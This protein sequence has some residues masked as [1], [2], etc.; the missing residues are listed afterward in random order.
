VAGQ[1][2]GQ[3]LKHVCGD[4]SFP[5]QQTLRQMQVGVLPLR[6]LIMVMP[7]PLLFS[8]D[9]PVIE[10]ARHVPLRPVRRSEDDVATAI[11][12]IVADG[13]T[14]LDASD[15]GLHTRSKKEFETVTPVF[16]LAQPV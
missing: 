3:T 10:H 14:R 7:S 15:S 11:D 4:G 1:G 9:Q 16:I 13:L 5:Q 8:Y 6:S 12:E 2:H